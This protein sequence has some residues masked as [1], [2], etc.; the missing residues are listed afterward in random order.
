MET[1][2]KILLLYNLLQSQNTERAFKKNNASSKILHFYKLLNCLSSRTNTESIK[3]ATLKRL[4][5]LKKEMM[6]C[7]SERLNIVSKRVHG[8]FVQQKEEKNTLVKFSIILDRLLVGVLENNE[9]V[10]CGNKEVWCIH[11]HIKNVMVHCKDILFC[12]SMTRSTVIDVVMKDDLT[13][14]RFIILTALFLS[15]IDCGEMHECNLEEYAKKVVKYLDTQNGW[16]HLE[17]Y[18]KIQNVLHDG[19]QDNLNGVVCSVVIL[20]VFF[21]GKL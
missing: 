8:Y 21:L 18:L 14:W 1:S 6:F 10:L 7:V 19:F 9:K 4:R 12:N 2:S 5:V 16:V 20:A 3:K 17:N 11:K 15:Q 13:W